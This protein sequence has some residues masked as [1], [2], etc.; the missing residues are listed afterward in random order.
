VGGERHICL[1]CLSDLPYSYFWEWRYNPAE[2]MLNRKL[3]VE[4]AVSLFIYREDSR[5]KSLIHNFKYGGDK[6]LGRYLSAMLGKKILDSGIFKSVDLII[7][8]P[9]HPLKRWKRG[10]NQA[11]V[12]AHELGRALGGIEVNEKVLRR[13][14]NTTSQT[15][16]DRD[17]REISVSKAFC[18]NRRGIEGR[19]VLLVD[20]VL[21]TGATIS[22]CGKAILSVPGTLLNVATLAYVE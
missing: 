6:V 21:T 9:L 14:K 4:K 2:E 20:D 13:R 18:L 3:D 12:I 17:E 22:A 10:F 15:I 19:E 8:V 7:P 16:K 11:A 5:W 1:K